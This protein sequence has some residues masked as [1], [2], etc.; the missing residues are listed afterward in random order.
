MQ[1][2][3]ERLDKFLTSQNI[4]SRRE[5]AKLIRS[6]KVTV[7]GQ[8]GAKPDTKILPGLTAVE[9]NGRPVVYR[10]HLY[11]MMNKPAGLIS[12]SQ[13][14]RAQTVLDILPGQW[15][16]RGMFPAG[17]L[18]KDT[19]G[20]LILTDDGDFA[21]R[22]LSPSRHVYKLYEARVRRPVTPEDA[23]AFAA[24]IRF[25]DTQFAPAELKPIEKDGEAYAAVRIREGKFHQVKRMFEAT[26]NEVLALKRLKIGGLPLDEHLQ[27]GECRL[28]TEEE[29][30]KIFTDNLYEKSLHNL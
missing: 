29:R 20:L 27:P 9:V 1:E 4:A 23:E 21:H 28:L 5:A 30:A 24:G 8:T 16:R 26:D 17:R 25:G 22:M 19:T 15:R 12:A 10:K 6:G 7:D 3:P 18:D 2:R 14:K 11:I 13:D